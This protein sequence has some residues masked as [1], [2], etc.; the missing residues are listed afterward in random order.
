VS[1]LTTSS[2][3]VILPFSHKFRTWDAFNRWRE[4]WIRGILA[5]PNIGHRSKT[6]AVVIY[7]H[8]GK[9]TGSAFP[10]YEAIGKA[11]GIDRRSAIAA[12]KELISAGYLQKLPRHDVHG[13]DTSNLYIP[14]GV[15]P[16]HPPGCCGDTLTY[17]DLTSPESGCHNDTPT[18]QKGRKDWS[19]R[20]TVFPLSP[21]PPQMVFRAA[22]RTAPSFHSTPPN[23][24]WLRSTPAV[25][26]A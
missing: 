15:M 23:G 5:D 9:D 20:T 26:L 25:S 19:T 2:S 12:V 22:R 1:L 16:R 3:A 14:V 7:L 24:R 8:L 4:Q 13:F 17:V 6:V 10:G 11:A 21:C 18:Y